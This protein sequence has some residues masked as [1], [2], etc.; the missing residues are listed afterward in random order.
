MKFPEF[1]GDLVED[2]ERLFFVAPARGHKDE[3]FVGRIV[4]ALAELELLLDETG[5]VVVVRPTGVSNTG[6][7]L[8]DAGVVKMLIIQR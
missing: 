2:V 3:A 6:V 4:E 1:L 8:V 5:V 7:P